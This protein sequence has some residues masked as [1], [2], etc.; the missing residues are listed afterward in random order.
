MTDKTKSTSTTYTD[1]TT[2]PWPRPNATNQMLQY[3]VNGNI[4]WASSTTSEVDHEL[5][6]NAYRQS[7]K[8]QLQTL[9]QIVSD[10]ADYLLQQIQIEVGAKNTVIYVAIGK[11]KN[12]PPNFVFPGGT[13][14]HTLAKKYMD[15]L[16]MVQL[17][18]QDA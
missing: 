16:A 5:I 9:T 13:I 8:G 7:F 4:D 11:D 3:P 1:S 17:V 18:L 6:K 2:V 10:N 15:W 12:T 14:S